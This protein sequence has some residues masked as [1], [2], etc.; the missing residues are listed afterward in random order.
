[1]VDYYLRYAEV[2]KLSSTTSSSVITHF[3][4]IF[5]RFGIPAEMVSNN[6]PQFSLQEMKDFSENYG[7]RHIKTSTHS[8]HK[9]KG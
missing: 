7:F 3:T 6:G 9:P 2:Q 1:M 8:I 5:A 4:S